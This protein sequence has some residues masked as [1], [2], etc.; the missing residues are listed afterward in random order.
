MDSERKTQETV[1]EMRDALFAL[2]FLESEEAVLGLDA[3]GVISTCSRGAW[4]LLGYEAGELEGTAFAALL[5]E[6]LRAKARDLLD[7]LNSSGHARNVEWALLM[8]DGG[9]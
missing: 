2:A 4:D 8:K 6:S 1:K 9:G 5:P 7:G 3:R